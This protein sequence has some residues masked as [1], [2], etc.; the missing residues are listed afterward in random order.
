M[1]EPNTAS[2]VAVEERGE[3]LVHHLRRV[4]P[5]AVEQHDDVPA[6]LDRVAVAGL[7]VAAVTEVALVAHDGD[8]Q[9]CGIGCCR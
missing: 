4:L 8:R 2:A 9:L 7:L 1:R 6:V 3:H 5:V